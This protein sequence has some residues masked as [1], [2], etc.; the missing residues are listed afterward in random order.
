MKK[1]YEKLEKGCYIQ[2]LTHHFK[3]KEAAKV[4]AN[5]TSR[6]CPNCDI[7]IRR[8]RVVVVKTNCKAD[9]WILAAA[10]ILAKLGKN[11]TKDVENKLMEIEVRAHYNAV[12]HKQMRIVAEGEEIY[13]IDLIFKFLS[14]AH[15]VNGERDVV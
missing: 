10:Q 3:T 15:K 12:H 7:H 2:T 5:K 4:Y 6:V 14:I 8:G 13:P 11:A 1:F 9:S